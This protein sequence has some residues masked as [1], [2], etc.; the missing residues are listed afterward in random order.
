MSLPLSVLSTKVV[1]LKDL[2]MSK[3]ERFPYGFVKILTDRKNHIIGATVVAPN[4]GAMIG[5][6]SVAIRHHLTILEITGTPHA[7]NSYSL[8]VKLAAKSLIK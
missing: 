5:E 7:T 3:I 2:P 4:A 6:L 1:Y 8:A